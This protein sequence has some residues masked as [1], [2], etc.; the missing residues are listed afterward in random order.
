MVGERAMPSWGV[1]LGVGVA[2]IS[3]LS[4]KSGMRLVLISAP[5]PQRLEYMIGICYREV[6]ACMIGEMPGGGMPAQLQ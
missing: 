6:V 2:L 3:S 4:L 5:H 1:G